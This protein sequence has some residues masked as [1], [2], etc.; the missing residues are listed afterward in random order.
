MP[1][2]YAEAETIL[3]KHYGANETVQR[4][5]FRGRLK[6]L[7]RLGIPLGSRPGKGKKILYDREQI[8]Q[9]AFCLELEEFGI[10]P[11]VIV[12]LVERLWKSDIA[13]QF[14]TAEGAKSELFLFAEPRF[15]SSGWNDPTNLGPFSLFLTLSLEDLRVFIDLSSETRRSL[16][17][18]VTKIVRTVLEGEKR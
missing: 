12:R 18:S 7:N 15:M 4:G 6:H 8:Y 2:T 5:A 9:W 11:S 13:P 16:I 1:F 14:L 10:D 17:V 3:A